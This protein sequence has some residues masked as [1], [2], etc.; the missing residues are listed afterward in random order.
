MD[1][2]TN[3]ATAQGANAQPE[4][5]TPTTE[6]TANSAPQTE[7]TADNSD[8]VL[9]DGDLGQGEDG[10]QSTETGEQKQV[11]PEDLEPADG[12]YKFY[13]EDGSEVSAEDASGFQDAFKEAHLTS[14]QAKILKN[15]YDKAVAENMQKSVHEISTSWK[16]AVLQDKELG[17][18][19]LPTTK[20]N[21]GRAMERFGSPEL[22]QFLNE[23]RLGN[24]P[25]MVRFINNVGKAVGEDR[26][27]GNGSSAS[28][29]K[30]PNADA[31]RWYPHSP[32]L[33]GNN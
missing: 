23:S 22:K 17:G 2:Q 31:Q 9:T 25:S 30:D 6:G 8:T 12:V 24:H 32:K 26:F 28:V 3:T 7:N 1:E 16:N 11:D 10:A 14:R 5:V 4:T 21:L 18:A 20:L 27:V 29:R 19:N 13:N 33:W 15:A